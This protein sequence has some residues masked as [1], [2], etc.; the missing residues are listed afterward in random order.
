VG[1]EDAVRAEGAGFDFAALSDHFHPWI[2]EQGQSPFAWTVLGGIATLSDRIEVGTAVTCPTIRIHPAIVAQAAATAA[3]MMPR[4]FFLG[5][6]TGER[7][8]EHITGAHWPRPDVRRDMLR[9]AVAAMRAL[10]SGELVTYRGRHCVVDGARLYT[11]PDEAP[12][13]LVAASG[14]DSASMAAEI[15]DG[16]IGTAPDADLLSTFRAEAG[17]GSRAYAEIT[18]CWNEDPGEA[19]ETA[20]RRWPN[21]AL[22]GSLNAELALPDQFE[23]AAGLVDRDDMLERIVVGPEVGDYVE[24]YARAGYDGVW[25]HQIGVDQE[26][27]TAFAGKELLPALMAS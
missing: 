2:D 10:W 20:M 6:G 12:P 13:V 9:E 24:A 8:N 21:A 4:R 7:L 3:T 5:V 17:N 22:P 18:V 15:G 26:G 27:F 14:P 25:F 1:I 16:L 19:L 23:D 11:V